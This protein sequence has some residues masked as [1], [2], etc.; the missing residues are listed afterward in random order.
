MP[1]E[2]IEVKIIGPIMKGVG[3]LEIKRPYLNASII[4]M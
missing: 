3:F 1:R 2:R 4:N